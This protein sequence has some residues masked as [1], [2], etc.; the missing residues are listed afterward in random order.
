MLSSIRR[1][2]KVC[3]AK[4]LIGMSMRR[5]GR[6]FST[7]PRHTLAITREMPKSFTNALTKFSDGEKTIDLAK[8]RR[9]KDE[10]LERLRRFV[11]TLCLPALHEHPDSVFVEDTA[12]IVQNRA[13][14]TNPGHPSR[15]GEVDTI[16]DVLIRL[17]LDVTDM[18]G[19]DPAA[20]CDGGDVLYTGKDLF[21]GLSERT[22]EAA[23]NILSEGLGV[24]NTIAVPFEGNALHL[25]SIVTHMDSS[26]LIVPIGDLGDQVLE[27]M[28][29]T[30]RG[31][32]IVRLPN[33]LACNVVSVNGGILAQ[34]AGCSESR[35]ILFS[36]AEERGLQLEFV[37]LSEAAKCDG[38]LTCCSL[39]LHIDD[40]T[41]S[42]FP[43]KTS[44]KPTSL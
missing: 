26:T 34:D 3:V 13:V 39:L 18:R 43:A 4:L 10:Y 5:R 32:S 19:V 44:D 12:V 23:V 17:G 27:A 37:S 33:M 38:A 25:K 24:T 22:N 30:S 8:A 31:Y 9:Q 35:K 11:P 1:L 41:K 42:F 7:V 20:L 15:R 29:A 36:A 14:V 21:V 2:E 16:K 6:P 28:D 40:F